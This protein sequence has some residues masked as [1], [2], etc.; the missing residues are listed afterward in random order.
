MEGLVQ[1]FREEMDR[2][3]EESRRRE[4]RML[5]E[6][7]AREEK[8]M[9]L[10]ESRSTDGV[11]NMPSGGGSF[12]PISVDRPMLCSSAT[13]SDFVTWKEG[14]DNFALCQH[15][16]NQ[17]RLVR[18]AALKTC[19]D[20]DLQRFLIQKTI[21]VDAD[22]DV[23]A[24]I[25]ALFKYIRAQRNPLL[26]RIEFY[27]AS[28]HSG[29]T[30]D[31]F[32]TGLKEVLAACNFETDP[33]CSTCKTREDDLMRDRIVCGI[34]SNVTRH[35]LLAEVDL[36]LEKA[37][38]ICQ[39]EE[40][41][42][43]SQKNLGSSSIQG[44]SAYK[45]AKK[46][47]KTQDSGSYRCDS[48]GRKTHGVKA[49]CPARDK[50]CHS[51]GTKGHFSPCC[52]KKTRSGKPKDT[53]SLRS[54]SS[55]QLSGIQATEN[56]NLETKI[57]DDANWSLV[58]WVPD[59]GSDIDAMDMNTFLSNGGD[60][61]D[62]RED[63][64]VVCNVSGTN[65]DGV[66][67][68]LIS[69]REGKNEVEAVLHVFKD[70]Q[71]CYLSRDTLKA[72]GYLPSNWPKIKVVSGARI[73]A[74]NVTAI[75]CE[76]IKEYHEVFDEGKLKPMRGPPMK[77]RLNDDAKPFQIFNAR[78]IAI[79]DEKQVK[80]QLDDMEADEIIEFVTEPSKWCHPIVIVD[81]KDSPEKRM[82][83]DLTKLNSQVKRPVH[84]MRSPKDAIIS[85]EGAR[86]FT[87]FDARHGYWQI[88]LDEESKPLTTFITPFGRY[89]FLRN[90]QGFIAAGDEFN[91]QIDLAF[92]GIPRMAKVVDDILVY[93]NDF[94]DHVQHVRQVLD[95]AREHGITLSLKKFEF[96][97]SEV[98]FCGYIVGCD[99]W[100]IDPAKT[101]ALRNFPAPE[102]R[103]DLRS[104]FGL[105]N[106]FS[107]FSSEV[108]GA[109][110]PLRGLL[111]DKN[112]F[113]WDQ[114]HN[115]AFENVKKALVSTPTLAYFTFDSKTRLETD[116]SRTR[117]LGFALLQEQNG[118]WRIIQCGSRFLS[119]AESRYA[120]IELELLTVVWAI[121]KCHVFVS[122]VKFEVVVDHKPLLPILNNYTL[123]KVD[124]KRLVRLLL[125]VQDYQFETVWKKGKDHVIADALSRAPVDQPGSDDQHG[126][127][128]HMS[129]SICS[130][131][132]KNEDLPDLKMAQLARET[133]KDDECRILRQIILDG[134][135]DKKSD[136]PEEIKPFWGAREHLH[137]DG[138]FI[139]HGERLVIPRC[140]RKMVLQDL[141]SS[142]QGQE[143]TKRRARQVVFWPGLNNDV[144]TILQYCEQC[145][146]HQ[147]SQ[148]KEPMMS[149]PVPDL[150]F[151]NVSSDLF[152]HCGYQYLVYVDR[153][154]GWPCTERL[155]RTANSADVI[156]VIRR[157]FSDLGVP[158]KIVTD[159]GPQ[160]SSRKFRDF[161]E[162]WSV[163]HVMSSPHYPQSNGH[164]ESAVKA[165]K[166]LLMKTTTNGDVDCDDFQK[167]MLEWRNTPRSDGRSP[168]MILFGR[169]LESFVFAYR[170]AFAPN[171]HKI[172][173]QFDKTVN[174][175]QDK[176]ESYY[177]RGARSLRPLRI[178]DYV[179]VQDFRSKLWNMSGLVVAIGSRRDYYIRTPSGRVYWR[180]RRF[181]RPRISPSSPI[182]QPIAYTSTPKF[183]SPP[184]SIPVAS[185]RSPPYPPRRS[186]RAKKPVDRMNIKNFKTKSYN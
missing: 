94:Q 25:S 105:V 1:V 61:K 97:K 80:V 40:G 176:S 100:K 53:P 148:P 34:G 106:Q 45:K 175:H 166:R 28:Q 74:Q 7:K 90:P 134:F 185:P 137:L 31:N 9:K 113:I 153:L 47:N 162:R 83:V 168:S 32:L 19:L 86:Y 78:K 95:R 150:P 182:L 79:N 42:V 55:I 171:W 63:R 172:A 167:G 108:A 170:K 68:C 84:P 43:S 46:M 99:G 3:L 38:K 159:G 186:S 54:M 60:L 85:M 77:I 22:A 65:M 24:I 177:N 36:T 138:D 17:S 64:D 69:I 75:K 183:P 101:K 70:I 12:R 26:D 133:R 123:D 107:D 135:P 44:V 119:D 92:E 57:S 147:A 62:L 35:R 149:E 179:D 33:S 156:R 10:I 4:D 104:F 141:H 49:L 120:M 109:A 39:A 164:A 132:Q 161:C 143:R 102:N 82:T 110:G 15:L 98:P 59:T 5:E 160:F 23:E 157:K 8:L 181:L 127:M 152:E 165:V 124:N 155:G 103:T 121:K 116:A 130:I 73:E 30:F 96:A 129:C 88:P 145:R 180:N 144:N 184:T 14:W 93:D 27:K 58:T 154:S 87:K 146:E 178:G 140:M 173:Q 122:G 20:S 18:V 139:L 142:H 13:S 2:L 114:A 115:Q 169:P 111:K 66:G 41:A 71:G 125:K 29:E 48:C 50:T 163:C 67:C 158:R 37:I 89:R 72:L 21:E 51:C 117:G 136:L 131:F 128:V 76:L 81:K 126:E 6:A 151:Q 112:A 56:L 174:H 118:V 52:P 16:A 11:S 91:M